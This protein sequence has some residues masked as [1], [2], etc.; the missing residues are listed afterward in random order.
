M[1]VTPRPLPRAHAAGLLLALTAVLFGFALGGAFGAAEAPIKKRLADSGDAVVATVYNGDAVAK[2][3]VVK[4]SW[5]YLQRAHLHGGAIGTAAAVAILALL[6]LCP[7]RPVE[8]ASAV[9]FGAGALLYSLFWLLA[10]FK[11][12]GMG[13]TGAAK[14]ALS[15]IAIPGAGLCLLG[16]LG[17]IVSVA[18]AA[19]T[20]PPE[21]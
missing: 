20:A 6:L 17:T 8:K 18:K 1:F 9:A 7:P 4:K 11:A 21:A 19:F 3:A 13:S 5:E 10:G 15:F 2:D 14:E 16:L 12:P